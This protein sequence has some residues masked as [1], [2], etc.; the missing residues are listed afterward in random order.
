M[1]GLFGNEYPNDTN[2]DCLTVLLEKQKKAMQEYQETIEALANCPIEQRRATPLPRNYIG[3]RIQYLLELNGLDITSFCQS[4]NLSRSTLHRYLKGTY[5]PS[6]KTLQII[7]EGL[8]LTPEKFASHLDN[9]E[10]WKWSLD[11][12]RMK[13][14]IFAMCENLREELNE[15]DFTYT[16]GDG[17][18]K[19]VPQQHYKAFCNLLDDAVSLLRLTLK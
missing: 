3:E 1:Y 9:F 2:N 17:T 18:V 4:M 5:L 16:A 13:T 19:K 7:I 12:G 8:W 6:K 10:V 14:D 11:S 15:Y